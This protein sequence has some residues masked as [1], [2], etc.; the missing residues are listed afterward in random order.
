MESRDAII[1]VSLVVDGLAI[2]AFVTSGLL[3]SLALFAIGAVLAVKGVR[4]GQKK[5]LAG[6]SM[7]VSFAAAGHLTPEAD[8]C[9]LST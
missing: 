6:V 1:Y 7:L 2:F 9:T 8:T 4:R 5:W 3:L